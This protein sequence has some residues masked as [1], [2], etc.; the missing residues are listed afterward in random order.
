VGL[1]V[2]DVERDSPADQAG[3][4]KGDVL[5]RADA[6]ELRSI[7]ALHAAIG[8]ALP[9]GQLALSAIRGADQLV[10]VA[11]VLAPSPDD[12]PDAQKQLTA[13]EADAHTI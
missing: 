6:R 4:R 13:N 7:V 10:T 2:G 11:V 5:V 8:Q 3:I 12:E 1:L 9:E